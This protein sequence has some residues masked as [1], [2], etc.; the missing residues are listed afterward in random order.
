MGKGCS[1]CTTRCTWM[2]FCYHLTLKRKSS[3][4]KVV[5]IS[6]FPCTCKI[7]V[8]K[9]VVNLK[10]QTMTGPKIPEKSLKYESA[11]L[12]LRNVF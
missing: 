6:V 9:C 3:W 12:R 1:N 4:E 5:A 11:K 10:I 2:E 7:V 8:K